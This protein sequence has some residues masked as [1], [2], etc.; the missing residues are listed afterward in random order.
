M[1][2]PLLA[3]SYLLAGLVC[4]EIRKNLTINNLENNPIES[5]TGGKDEVE[6]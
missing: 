2:E 5:E 6:Q 1:L 4:D 3:L